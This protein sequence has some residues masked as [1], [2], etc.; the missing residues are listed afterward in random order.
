MINIVVFLFIMF[1][2]NLKSLLL[3]D[4]KINKKIIEVKESHLFKNMN[5][6]SLIKI[7]YSNTLSHNHS[8][9]IENILYKRGIRL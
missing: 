4:F 8:H 7:Y 9:E 1:A 2:N 5:N 6:N 3:K